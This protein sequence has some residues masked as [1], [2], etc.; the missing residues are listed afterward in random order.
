M[1]FAETLK[2][3]L[4]LRDTEKDQYQIIRHFSENSEGVLSLSEICKE[5]NINKRWTSSLEVIGIF[6]RIILKN[7]EHFKFS[8]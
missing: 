8:I 1:V 6:K 4:K 3:N 5:G 7:P 2:R